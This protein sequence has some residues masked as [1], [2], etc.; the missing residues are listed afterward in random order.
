[1][2]SSRVV[3]LVD[4]RVLVSWSWVFSKVSTTSMKEF[5]VLVGTGRV[6]RAALGIRRDGTTFSSWVLGKTTVVHTKVLDFRQTFVSRHPLEL[7]AIR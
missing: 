1:M 6:N 4:R 2:S 7:E 3:V 5:M